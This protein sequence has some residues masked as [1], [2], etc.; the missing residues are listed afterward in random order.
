MLVTRGR[1]T[2]EPL[3]GRRSRGASF[4]GMV[5]RFLEAIRLGFDFSEKRA[6]LFEPDLVDEPGHQT[7]DQYQSFASREFAAAIDQCS[8]GRAVEPLVER[9][10]PRVHTRVRPIR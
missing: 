5:D 7:F 2:A 1:R 8:N 10:A 6:E 4:P 3:A 9:A